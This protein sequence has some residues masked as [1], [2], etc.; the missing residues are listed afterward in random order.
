[1][2]LQT[3]MGLDLYFYQVNKKDV[4]ALERL[5]DLAKNESKEVKDFL[6]QIDDYISRNEILYFRNN[7]ELLDIFQLENCVR[8]RITEDD[9]ESA[10]VEMPP[11]IA[12]TFESCKEKFDFENF[13]FEGYGW[14]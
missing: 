8:K 2:K 7:W 5:E 6:R 9:L 11:D 3:N 13:Y 12:E 14:Y 10:I 1:M 4:Q